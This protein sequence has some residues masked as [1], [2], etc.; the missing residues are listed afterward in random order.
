ML[1]IFV[2]DEIENVLYNQARLQCKFGD[3][4]NRNKD[5]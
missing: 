2:L 1:N 3:D 5:I 4:Q